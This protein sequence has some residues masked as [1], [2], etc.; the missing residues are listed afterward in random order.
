MCQ[1]TRKSAAESNARSSDGYLRVGS[2]HHVRLRVLMATIGPP[3]SGLS[4]LASGT[5]N[6]RGIALRWVCSLS[7]V[8]FVVAFGL[9]GQVLPRHAR[10]QSNPH[11]LGISCS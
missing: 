5:G 10:S 3:S 4:R 11:G 6:R 2:F 9:S 7:V 8:M 1:M